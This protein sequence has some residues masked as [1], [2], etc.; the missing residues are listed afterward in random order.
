[1]I[2]IKVVKV[3]VCGAAARNAEFFDIKV[4]HTLPFRIVREE[5]LKV[6]SRH[7]RERREN[8]WQK[9]SQ[10]V[11]DKEKGGEFIK[12]HLFLSRVKT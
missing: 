4:P 7:G 8:K 10:I 3:Y 1:M 6:P 5:T 9:R 2:L 12:A 11:S